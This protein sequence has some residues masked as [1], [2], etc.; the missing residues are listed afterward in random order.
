LITRRDNL[1]EALGEI[2]ADRLPQASSIVVNL[3]WWASLSVAEQ[4]SYRLRADRAR[5][6]LIADDALSSHFVEVRGE[7]DGPPLLTERRV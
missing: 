6:E 7:G 2:E 5:I 1:E 4:E 3:Q